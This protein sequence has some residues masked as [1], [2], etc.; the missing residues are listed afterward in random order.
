[1]FNCMIY[2]WRGVSNGVALLVFVALG[3]GSEYAVGS[4]LGRCKRIHSTRWL[5]LVMSGE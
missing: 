2:G 1:M 5:A 3:N 4:R